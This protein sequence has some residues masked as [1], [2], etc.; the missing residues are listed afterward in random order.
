MSGIDRRDVLVSAGAAL[1]LASLTARGANAQ[2]SSREAILSAMHGLE[3]IE[4]PSAVTVLGTGGSGCWPALLAAMSGVEEILLLDASDV[5]ED[6]LGRTFFRP[7]DIGRPKAEATAEIISFFRPHV[8]TTAIKRFVEPGEEDIY[9]G[10]VLFDGVDYPPLNSILPAEAEK[11]GM[12]YTQGFYQGLNA[13]VTDR[14]YEGTAWE[15][16]GVGPVWPAS[17][18]L[19]GILQ[20]YSAF[21]NGMNYFGSPSSL[22]M[23]PEV[24][25]EVFLGPDLPTK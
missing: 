3:G 15:E 14:Y 5:S 20:I 6:D 22:S 24:M 2:T 10:A 17:A 1:T 25:Q 8:K 23:S 9:F 19:S 18:A 11:R 13:G 4:I 12:R 21:S 7:V 16:G